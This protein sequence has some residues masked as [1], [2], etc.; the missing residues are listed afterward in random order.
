M[1]ERGTEGEKKVSGREEKIPSLASS[2]SLSSTLTGDWETRFELSL[3]L[4][5]CVSVVRGDCR[6]ASYQL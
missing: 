2:S 4:I 3:K 1:V 6:V 5:G